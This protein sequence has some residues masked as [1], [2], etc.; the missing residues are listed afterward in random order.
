LTQAQEIVEYNKQYFFSQE[1]FTLV[2]NE[3]RKN[4]S[5]AL[6]EVEKTNTSQ[7]WFERR[8]ELSTVDEIR[9][10]LTGA[11]PHPNLNSEPEYFL[12]HTRKNIAKV[13]AM[14]KKFQ[15]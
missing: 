5:N 10:I 7:I 12:S 8:R 4:L 3:L 14:A 13:V 11:I 2:S 15:N 1:F 9:N 6:V